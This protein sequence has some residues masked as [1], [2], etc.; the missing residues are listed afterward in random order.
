MIGLLYR[1]AAMAVRK[2]AVQEADLLA[3]RGGGP[4]SG[5]KERWLV[6]EKNWRARFGGRERKRGGAEGALVRR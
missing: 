2:D 5:W 1:E 4:V 6:R 3:G